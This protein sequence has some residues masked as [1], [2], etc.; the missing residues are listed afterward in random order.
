MWLWT[1]LFISKIGAQCEF[2]GN[3]PITDEGITGLNLVINNA[4]ND[5]LADPSQGV[6]QV[7]I[8]FKHE[9]V[10]DLNI[11]L[12]SPSNQL[13]QLIGAGGTSSG[14]TDATVWDIKFTPCLSPASPDPGYS[15][16]WDNGDPWQAFQSY[17][18]TYYP[19]SGCLE[20]FN[21]GP[22]NGTWTL[23]VEDVAELDEG[24]IEYFSIIFCD[25][26][27]IDCSSCLPPIASFT[28]D[29]LLLCRGINYELNK[30]D[31]EWQSSDPDTLNYHQAFLVFNNHV[32][33]GNLPDT[34]V[35]QLDTGQY[36]ICLLQYHK[37]DSLLVD[38]L[39]IG[40]LDTLVNEVLLQQGICGLISDCTSLSILPVADTIDQHYILCQGDTLFFAGQSFS[41]AGTYFI[42]LQEGSCDSVVALS[43]ELRK[44]TP[45]ISY[46][47]PILNCNN[48]FIDIT[49]SGL[50]N[51]ANYS[52][53]W[54]T[55]NGNFL[56]ATDSS[57]VRVNAVGDYYLNLT[58]G[59]CS[60]LDTLIVTSDLSIPLLEIT[61][62][63][64]TCNNANVTLELSS[65]IPL[66]TVDWS[67][68]GSITAVG[69]NAVVSQSGI[70]RAEVVDQNGCATAKSIEVF[71]NLIQP[72]L[73]F[74]ISNI[75][76]IQ[77]FGAITILDSSNIQQVQW[78]GP[79]PENVNA[80]DSR[81]L[82]AGNYYLTLTGFNGCDTII[83]IAIDDISYEVD[84]VLPSD[85]LNCL[86]KQTQLI[87]L[88]SRVI[89]SQLWTF[90]DL[91]AVLTNDPI[92]TEAGTYQVVVTDINGCT[93]QASTELA[94]DTLVPQPLV[95]D[96]LI[97]CDS[98]SV[99][100]FV[101][102]AK[103]AYQYQWKGPGAFSSTAGS[104][105]VITP[106]TYFVTVVDE[107]GCSGSTQFEVRLSQ[108]LPDIG[109][110][111]D[112]IT[113]SNPIAS[114]R[115]SDTLG[116]DF[117]WL[118]PGML[119]NPQQSI[120]MTDKPGSYNVRITDRSNGCKRDYFLGVK[121]SR[122]V[123]SY[124]LSADTL[125]CVYSVSKLR[126]SGDIKVK[127]FMWT[128]PGFVSTDAEPTVTVAGWYQLVMT[129]S[130]DCVY[131]DSVLVM[132]D[133]NIPRVT[134]EG[135]NINCTND[136]ATLI[137]A[138]TSG[139]SIVWK[140]DD[141]EL[142][143]GP[144]ITVFNPGIYKAVAIGQ[145]G[146]KD[147]TTYTVLLDTLKPELLILP[148]P[149]LGCQRDSVVL[150][151]NS[152]KAIEIYEWKGPDMFLSN[153]AETYVRL[154]GIYTLT[155]VDSS[156]CTAQVQ[157]DVFE[158]S[159]K[160]EYDTLVNPITCVNAGKI[161]ISF[162]ESNVS[163]TWIESPVAIGDGTLSF[164]SMIGGIY[165]FVATSQSGCTQQI[166]IEL[167]S[168]TIAPSLDALSIGTITCKDTIATIGFLEG[169]PTG[170][171]VFWSDLGVIA[172]SI[173]VT[174]PGLYPGIL[175]GINGCTSP[176][177]ALVTEDVSEPVFETRSDTIDCIKSKTDL[178][179]I[180][181][182][183]FEKVEWLSP[184][185]TQY[186][187]QSVKVDMPGIYK[188]R[189]TAENGCIAE[190]SARVE[191]DFSVPDLT[192]TDSFYLPCNQ[193]GVLLNFTSKDSILSVKWVGIDQSFFATLAEVS[194]FIP[195]RI[196]ISVSSYNGCEAIDTIW[197]VPS[198]ERPQF[199]LVGDT[200]GCAPPFAELVAGN[201]NDDVSFYWKSE[202]GQISPGDTLKT[203]S[204][205]IYKLIVEGQNGCKD[206]LSTVVALD[207][208]G[209]QLLLNAKGE[210]KCKNRSVQLEAEILNPNGDY[211]FLWTTDIGNFTGEMDS[212][213]T[214]INQPGTYT[215]AA[216]SIKNGCTGDASIVI[217]EQ[218]NTL[219]AEF[220]LIHPKCF[221]DNNGS[222]SVTH[223][224][225]GVP[226]YVL[227][228]NGVEQSDGSLENLGPG[229]YL[230][231]IEDSLGCLFSDTLILNEGSMNMI[232]LPNDTLIALGNVLDI[233]YASN[234]PNFE[235]S[236][237]EWLA[238]PGGSSL[239]SNCNPLVLEA[240]EDISVAILARDSLGC[241]A[242]DTMS[243]VVT[244]SLKIDLPNSLLLS[245]ED[246]NRYFFIASYP[247]IERV[248][249]LRIYDNW[250]N[251]IFVREDF[252]PGIPEL[253]WDGKF[254]GR[255]VNPG[256]FVYQ[257]GIRLT[258][259]QR[260]VR[261]R[262]ITVVK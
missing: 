136:A 199:F 152:N 239:C 120:G 29:S 197:V 30:R 189:V 37:S 191:S 91:S 62:D 118:T 41:K 20:D 81:L 259:G 33:V 67:G 155:V 195:N 85:T 211:Q 71:E 249:Y 24:V 240:G 188:V 124:V 217:N 171:S 230:A 28:T 170:M 179:I 4:I 226:P 132:E 127:S 184:D 26:Q 100:I 222:V 256:V 176:F 254:R 174:D 145:S 101:S 77:K 110:E 1:L 125:G 258:N 205:G 76:C 168:D 215:I 56:S 209:P 202:T 201:V 13:V 166:S 3:L 143:N 108:D 200:I 112:S 22:V 93:G 257:L 238:I 39:P 141:F 225:E 116:L 147:S 87:P 90:P 242:R 253:G 233:Y 154:P 194:A 185:G 70:Y 55:S 11:S 51:A 84:V 47:N 135:Q 138:A 213:Q 16:F 206:S 2:T 172:D 40:F 15:Q 9:V 224:L 149:T 243:I 203:A 182:G 208:L 173:Q 35:S 36:E 79:N 260:I 236:S 153:S 146:C 221:G 150:A 261:T 223:I 89:A 19:N 46:S 60:Y 59:T 72:T 237:V 212:S 106:G 159:N 94:M 248:E 214:Q 65:N 190:D 241:L 180:G 86:K 196:K 156:G 175:T 137:A 148:P 251:L 142:G 128:G 262:D 247:F 167:K 119:N 235:W 133:L 17:D 244:S 198:K 105:R 23:L 98:T 255:E 48:E 45:E 115:P 229:K 68:P 61:A 12:I 193:N 130:T 126:V 27:G 187:G 52:F 6:C 250:G 183:I 75:D 178:A 207:T 227:T 49:L 122:E 163:V 162:F 151:A 169:L 216:V 97:D 192:V 219:Q 234:P 204:P 246:Q 5:N 83:E 123:A 38:S 231:A 131:K 114:I 104:E 57:V 220:S 31:L 158:D 18:G 160:L 103:P 218:D 50:D 117:L 58:S 34:M 109:F 113:C 139:S 252:E 177:Q 44:M 210:I 102:N 66:L 107:N 95:T 82:S 92:V 144:F 78:I 14:F 32:Y 134:I 88:S 53:Q 43:I 42:N 99:L 245:G 186:L 63:E 228:I 7:L 165:T 140:Q 161:E 232:S 69:Q 121:D 181:N 96:K 8:K 80:I 157:T 64:I 164:E 129:D 74:N 10:G 73:Q 111:I 21:T 54:S 25:D